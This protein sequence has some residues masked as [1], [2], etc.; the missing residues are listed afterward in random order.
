MNKDVCLK[1]MAEPFV[2]VQAIIVYKSAQD[3]YLEVHTIN[4]TS[5][6]GFHFEEGHPLEEDTLMKI[7][8]GLTTKKN[9]TFTK[10]ELLPKGILYNCQVPGNFN[11]IWYLMK[12]K[13][14]LIFSKTLKL[15]DTEVTLPNLIFQWDGEHLNVYC[16]LGN[17]PPNSAT[18]L[19]RSPFKNTSNGRVCLGNAE[20][21]TKTNSL[22]ELIKSAENAFL[23]SRFTHDGSDQSYYPNLSWKEIIRTGVIPVKKLIRQGINLSSIIL[24]YERN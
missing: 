6:K 21:N 17:K 22:S 3:F 7:F 12:P 11:I 23:G 19:Y 2:P 9:Q 16:F 5:R 8:A 14:K 10:V 24:H 13:R 18:Q 1:K 4:N 20:V 15:K